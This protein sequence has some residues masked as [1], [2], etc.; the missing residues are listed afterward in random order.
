MNDG[1]AMVPLGPF[2]AADGRW[3]CGLRCTGRVPG[4]PCPYGLRVRPTASKGDTPRASTSPVGHGLA[5]PP[6][7]PEQEEPM[8][9]SPDT[10][11]AP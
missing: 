2:N 4:V 5:E 11:T 1:F 6:A 10:W 8:D 7:P 9:T 3:C